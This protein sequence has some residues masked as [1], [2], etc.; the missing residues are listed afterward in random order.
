M[1]VLSLALLSG[2]K[3]WRCHKLRYRSQMQLGS[4]VA[5]AVAAALIR[6]LDWEPAAAAGVALKTNKQKLFKNCTRPLLWG[7]PDWILERKKDMRRKTGVIQVKS[8]L[9]RKVPMLLSWFCWKMSMCFILR[10]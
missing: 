1:Q 7:T 5:V 9:H 10:G 6:P 3:T 4:S 8:V 2:L